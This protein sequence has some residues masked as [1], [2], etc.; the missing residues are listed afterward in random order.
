MQ[1]E[2]FYVYFIEC[3]GGPGGRGI[4]I[5]YTGHVEERYQK[6]LK[7]RGALYTKTHPPVRLIATLCFPSRAQAMRVE[8]LLKRVARAWKEDWVDLLTI[9]CPFCEAVGEKVPLAMMAGTASAAVEE[10]KDLLGSFDKPLRRSVEEIF[11]IVCPGCV[12]VESAGC[13]ARR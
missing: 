11:R 8:K 3:S 5:G 7:G 2:R 9:L 13:P 10:L 1:N 4:Y 12:R 6:H